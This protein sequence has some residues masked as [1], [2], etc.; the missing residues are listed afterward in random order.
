MEIE[1]LK[2]LMLAAEL[3]SLNKAA[4][5]LKYTQAGLTRM[6]NSLENEVG[7]QL[8]NRRYNGVS[9]TDDAKSLM[10]TIRKLVQNYDALNEEME[11]IR[12]AHKKTIHVATLTSVASQ[13]I[14]VIIKRFSK[15][16][17][18]VNV[19]FQ[20]ADLLDAADQLLGDAEMDI[21]FTS[22]LK[23]GNFD[24]I[25]LKNDPLLAVLP[26][27][28][29]NG[30]EPF[31]RL[32]KFD[33]MDFYVSSP[34]FDVDMMHVMETTNAKPNYKPTNLDDQALI[35]LI[36][37]GMGVTILPEMAVRGRGDRTQLLPVYPPSYRDL[38]LAVRSLKAVTPEV[39]DFIKISRA[40]AAE[41]R[42][43][44]K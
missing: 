11:H 31:F 25:H 44:A 41:E 36:E 8:L 6:M 18:D 17:P 5:S 30:G 28:Y 40:V 3:G 35:N 10:P 37:N 19:D 13:W 14:P 24:W 42:N 43:R 39:R 29:D 15:L 2:A 23:K 33:G 1:K 20:I 22:M 38:G 9:L 12:N 21:V 4:E 34:G 26:P 32:E 16:H 27:D 7:F